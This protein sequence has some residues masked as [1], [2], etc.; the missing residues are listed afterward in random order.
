M[1]ELTYE[2]MLKARLARDPS[3]DG[4]F[5][6]GI[7]STGIY[8]LP[9]CKAKQAS[10]DNLL[11][12]LSRD[13]A[14]EAGFRG[15]KRCKA[16]Q[17]PNVMPVWFED[18]ISYMKS[19][20]SI[21]LDENRLSEIAQVDITTIRRHFKA[22]FNISLMTYHRKLRLAHAKILIDNGADYLTAAFEI[23]FQSVSG[24]RE[25]FIKEYGVT[26]AEG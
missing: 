6:V 15:C 23:G 11:F 13:E 25:A 20:M 5:Y 21:K 24:F 26:P 14:D 19:N 12:F 2:V 10:K 8:C 1:Q 3:Y 17:F 18:V 4:K 7:I 9:S 16:E 22:H